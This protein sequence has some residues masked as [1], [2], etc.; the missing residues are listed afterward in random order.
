M[1]QAFLVW[2]QAS[3]KRADRVAKQYK[4]N[5]PAGVV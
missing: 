4:H 2:L 3:R 1:S 5:V